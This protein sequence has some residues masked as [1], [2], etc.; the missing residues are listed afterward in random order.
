MTQPHPP[1]DSHRDPEETPNPGDRL[2]IP[3]AEET[4]DARVV[5]TERRVMRV[6]KGVETISVSQA[7]TLEQGDVVVERQARNEP[8]SERRAPWYEGDVLM[9]PLYEEVPVTTTQLMLREVVVIRRTVVSED[10][11]VD[12]EIR[13]DVVNIEDI[14]QT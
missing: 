2:T 6:R 4:L 7:L 9:V 10:V 12:A 8:A 13:R 1:P 3:L 11:I 14:D 5:D